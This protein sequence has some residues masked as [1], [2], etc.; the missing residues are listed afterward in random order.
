[1]DR[2][3]KLV[4]KYQTGKKST[5]PEIIIRITDEKINRI[6]VKS[7]SIYFYLLK[8]PEHDFFSITFRGQLFFVFHNAGQLNP[9]RY[10]IPIFPG[11]SYP[12]LPILQW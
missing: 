1:M 5:I 4:G 8:F 7:N 3:G 11:S 10:G 6:V 9:L 12:S 2:P